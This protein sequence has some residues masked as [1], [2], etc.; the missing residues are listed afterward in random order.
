MPSKIAGGIIVIDGVFFQLAGSGIARVWS[1]LLEQWSQ[2]EFASRLV[3]LDRGRT[4]RFPGLRYRDTPP[5]SY[6]DM[7]GDRRLVQAICD[8]EQATL[9]ISTYYTTP[10]HTRSVLM[11]YDMIPELFGMDM[12]SAQWSQKTQAIQ[13]ASHYLTISKNTAVD[14]LRTSDKAAYDLAI[15]HCGCNFQPQPRE[16]IAAFLQKH[17]ITR[18]YFMLSGSRSGYKNAALFFAGFAQLG[19]R[20]KEFAIVCT[21]G[22]MRLEDDCLPHVGEAS[23][24]LLRIP[25]HEI[26]CAY[27]GALALVYP[28]LY[29]GFGMPP[30]EAMACGTPVITTPKASLP[31]VCGDAVIYVDPDRLAVEQMHQALLAVLDQDKRRELIEKGFRQANRFSWAKMAKTVAE[32][33]ERWLAVA[34]PASF[35]GE[36]AAIKPPRSLQDSIELAFGFLAAGDFASARAICDQLIADKIENF[37]PFYLSGIIAGQARDWTMA[38]AHLQK[39]LSFSKGVP[40]ERIAEVIARLEKVP[41]Q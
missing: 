31:E 12:A 33:L 15:A 21:G 3:I 1:S 7:E 16:Q 18:P 24:H 11:L 36:T 27:C 41:S 19:E 35:P 40:P 39:A 28:S 37:Y 26:Q 38:R 13:Y 9:F 32:N 4:P 23:V 6:L 22:D 14:L 10:L 30:L 25:D 5:L 2:T 34:R 29:E 8:E 17:E 20:R